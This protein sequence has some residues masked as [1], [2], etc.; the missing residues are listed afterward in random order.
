MINTKAN[1]IYKIHVLQ[2]RYYRPLES[3]ADEDERDG[4]SDE[5]DGCTL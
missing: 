3:R 4:R 5:R 2:L 1:S